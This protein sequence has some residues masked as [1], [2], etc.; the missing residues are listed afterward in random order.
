LVDKLLHRSEVL[1]FPHEL[2]VPTPESHTRLAPGTPA[3]IPELAGLSLGLHKP[4]ASFGLH[5]DAAGDARL[6]L[7]AAGPGTDWGRKGAESAVLSV[8]LDGKYQQDVVLWGGSKTSPYA[9]S[10][11]NLPAGDHTVTVRY[12]REKSTAGAQG[13]EIAAGRAEA[14]AYPSREERWAA[15][16]APILIGKG[17]LDNNHTDTPLGMYHTISQNPDGT[18]TLS[19]AY[20]FSNEDEGTAANPA[21][22]AARWGRLTDLQHVMNVTV[23][24]DGRVVAERIEGNGHKV[25]DFKGEHDGTH[26]IIRTSSGNNNVSDDGDGPLRFRMTTDNA[27][28]TNAPVEDLMRTRPGW[29]EAM[30][31]EVLREGKVDPDGVGDKPDESALG[32]VQIWLAQHGLGDLPQMADPRNYLYVQ[33]KAKGAEEHPVEVRVRLKNGEVRTSAMGVEAAQIARDGWAQ[34]TVQ[35][36]PGTKPE[37]VARVDFVSD[38]A[39]LDQVGHTFML[40]PAYHPV[41]ISPAGA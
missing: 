36:P 32:K 21:L 14:V 18:T 5:M 13:I 30:G 16:Y 40:D 28:P 19:Y 17:G 26:P 34:T 23:D 15:Q 39:H 35:L 4:L 22:E 11:G 20:A 27:V 9:L 41:E 31:K 29:F 12:A 37:D 1:P 24:P 7:E 3:A 38:G 6:D 10:L 2:N 33:F 25:R 8:Y